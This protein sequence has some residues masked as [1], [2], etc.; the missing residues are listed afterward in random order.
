MKKLLSTRFG[1]VSK[2]LSKFLLVGVMFVTL[3]A[4]SS[5]AHAYIVPTLTVYGTGDGNTVNLT[6]AG[7]PNVSVVF[8]YLKSGS[9]QQ[10]AILGNT[11]SNGNYT[12]TINSSTY[13]ILTG[14]PV[15]V[16]TDGIGGLS[17]QTLTWPTVSTTVSS[18][19]FSLSPS[20]VVLSI[21]QSTSVIANNSSGSLYVSN[22]SNPSVAT[23]NL[24]GT[25]ISVVGNTS[26]TSVVTICNLGNSVNCPTLYVD[27]LNSGAQ[28]LSFSQN[29]VTLYTGQSTPITVAGGNGIYTISN[30]SNSSLIFAS[31]SGQTLTLST[32]ASTGSAS[33]TI[34][35]SDMSSCGV[36]NVTVGLTN[37]NATLTFSQQ[38]PTISIGQNTT[39]SVYGGSN[40]YYI[41]SNQNSN[42][43]QANISG[44]VLTLYGITSGTDN[45]TICATSGGCSQLLVTVSYVPTGGAL[46]LSQSTLSLSVNQTL[47][48]TISGGSAPY[49]LPTPTGAIYQANISTNI[50][51]ITG[52]SVGTAQVAVCS[53]SGGCTWLTLTVNSA[54]SSVGQVSFSQS[55][56]SL[57]SGQ[58]S[59][60]SIYGSG[61]YYI[62]SNSNSSIANATISGNSVI[63]NAVAYGT[64]SI[65]VCQSGGECGSLYVTVGSTSTGGQITFS[66]SN[67]T[68]TSGQNSNVTVYGTGPYYVSTNSNSSVA[69]AVI[70]G[71]SVLINALSYGT[72]NI[73][74]CQSGGQCGII[75]VNVTTSNNTTTTG[76]TSFLLLSQYTPSISVGQTATVSILNGVSSVYT[77]GYNS[78]PNSVTT[79]L[80][81]NILT[82]TGIRNGY[83]VIIVCDTNNDC[84]PVIAS[85][86]Y[87]SVVIPSSLPASSSSGST[88]AISGYQFTQTLY[89]GSI[90]TEVSRLQERLTTEGVYSGPVNGRFGPLT[91]AAVK[92][93]Q[94]DHGITP[95]G[96]VG[97]LTRAA[98]NG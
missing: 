97:A 49:N 18:N 37:T 81:G 86:G 39:I 95:T 31:M 5:V 9:G 19:Q 63:V 47:S 65:T 36:V 51:N 70:N 29:N 82:L 32:S 53:A 45:L 85:V 55:S 44:S 10:L 93:Y 67:L 20:A 26:G 4:S 58:S 40:S 73:N 43:L 13:G 24:S 72:T 90:G 98:L 7:D 59:T 89:L 76:G 62:S 17:S 94:T 48:I 46:A 74:V 16:T 35:S 78:N 96:N 27:V 87:S 30:N 23:V 88:T 80:N 60:V 64:T 2:N 42:I 12:T 3:F 75:Y 38:N 50:L 84:S 6:V 52:T 34:C 71:S 33:I 61:S 1:S 57:N 41:S 8:Y 83:S 92:K 66:Q 28:Q 54:G 68:M 15:H 25:S 56:L 11:D 69:G 77:V 14:T 79:T 22:N 21:G 91:Q